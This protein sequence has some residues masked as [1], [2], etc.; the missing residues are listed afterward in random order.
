M[1]GSFVGTFFLSML[2]AGLILIG[3]PDFW[4][5]VALGL[6]I[7]LAAGLDLIVRRTAS[8]VLGRTEK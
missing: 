4:D 3:V 2:P 5:G 6:V 8:R 1:F 7:L